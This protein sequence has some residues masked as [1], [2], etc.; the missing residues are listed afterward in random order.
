MIRVNQE[1][2]KEIVVKTE[3]KIV[4]LII[5]GLGGLTNPETGKSELETAEIPNLNRLVRDSLCGLSIPIGLGITPGSGPAHLVL[6]G[7][8]PLKYKIGRGILEALGLGIEVQKDA[9]VARANFATYDYKNNLVLDRRA[10]RIP[11]E[12]CI[13]LCSLLQKKTK[14]IN[15]T[16]IFFHPGKGHRFVVVFRGKNLSEEISENDPQKDGLP[17]VTIKPLK[18]KAEKTAK[19]VNLFLTKTIETLKKLTPANYILL[20]G[21]SGYPNLPKMEEVY[22]LKSA[23]I[24]TY[25]MYRGIARLLGM[26]ILPTGEKLEDEIKSLEENFAD[27]NFFYLHIKETDLYGEDGNFQG[28]VRKL[29]EIDSFIP[30]IEALHPEVLVITGD[31]STPAVLKGHSWHPVPFLLYSKYAPKDG[32]N[33]FTERECRFGSLGLF[34]AKEIMSLALGYAGKL[35]KYGA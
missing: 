2:I 35:T 17:A 18:P 3:S 33:K 14:K 24:A 4:F 9:L 29:E 16:E 6:F 5:D 12:K 30:K 1:I 19:L 27:Y 8:E 15:S 11:T 22:Q 21:F 7:Y 34:P 23:A 32:L 28:K 13:E 31:H 26:K 20:R 10:G 25:P